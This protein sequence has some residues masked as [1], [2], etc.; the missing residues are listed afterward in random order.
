[1]SVA[2]DV[3][4]SSC[5]ATRRG[6]GQPAADPIFLPDLVDDHVGNKIVDIVTIL[7]TKSDHEGKR[8][9]VWKKR[10]EHTASSQHIHTPR[11]RVFGCIPV[12]DRGEFVVYVFAPLI[13]VWNLA[14][15]GFTMHYIWGRMFTALPPPSLSPPM[16]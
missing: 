2:S 4:S 11:R 13:L 7:G 15:I 9:P 16:V 5:R 10:Q 12:L 3:H 6:S 1:M 14:I 8:M